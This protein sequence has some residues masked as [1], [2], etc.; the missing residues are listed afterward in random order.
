MVAVFGGTFNPVH[1][2]HL[3]MAQQALSHFGLEKVIFIP[4]RIPPHKQYKAEIPDEARLELLHLATADN[5]AFL[6]SDLELQR[7][8]VSYSIDTICELRDHYPGR[9]FYLIGEDL[10][11]GLPEW[12]DI[13]QLSAMVEFAVAPRLDSPPAPAPG[14]RLHTFSAPRIGISST[15][16]RELIKKSG[17]IHYLVPEAVRQRIREKGYYRGDR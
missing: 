14:I 8:G 6:V 4:D 5:P 2:G 11:P 12:K 17:S 9:L 13:G 1:L 10:V 3:V 15:M 7:E 16:I